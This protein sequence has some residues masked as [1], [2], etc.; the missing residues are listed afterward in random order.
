M[1]RNALAL[2]HRK[3]VSI[4]LPQIATSA[5]VAAL[6]LNV[7]VGGPVG[8][9]TLDRDR[10]ALGTARDYRPVYPSVAGSVLRKIRNHGDCSTP[11]AL[12]ITSH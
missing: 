2:R 4:I 11:P 5:F 12:T 7:R 6:P 8:S 10:L 1:T 3:T 9:G